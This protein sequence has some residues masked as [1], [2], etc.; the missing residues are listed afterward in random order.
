MLTL[1]LNKIYYVVHVLQLKFLLLMAHL[2][3][4]N[5]QGL[6]LILT[7]KPLKVFIV[8]STSFIM[9]TKKLLNLPVFVENLEFVISIVQIF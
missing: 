5:K 2:F 4:D 8:L 1:F 6:K 7:Q 3:D 9:L